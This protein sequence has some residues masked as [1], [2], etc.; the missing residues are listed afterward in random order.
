METVSLKFVIGI[1]VRYEA[2]EPPP[3]PPG[4]AAPADLPAL[5]LGRVQVFYTKVGDKRGPQLGVTADSREEAIRKT[6]AKCLRWL[7]THCEHDT[8]DPNTPALR[9]VTSIEFEIE[10]GPKE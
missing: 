3:P 7:A 5:P 10:E 1:G 9:R 2:K 8:D 4:E 6:K